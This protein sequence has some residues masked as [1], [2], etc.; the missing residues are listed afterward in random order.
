M[1]PVKALEKLM[2]D[3][4]MLADV[5]AYDAPRRV[6]KTVTTNSSHWRSSSAG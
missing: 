1:I 6:W 4:E 5:K 2:Q 3:A